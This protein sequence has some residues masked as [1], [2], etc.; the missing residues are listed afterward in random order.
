MRGVVSVLTGTKVF[1]HHAMKT[2]AEVKVRMHALLISA[3]VE[4]SDQLH[5]PAALTPG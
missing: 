5:D 1:K 2:R 4:V 3:L